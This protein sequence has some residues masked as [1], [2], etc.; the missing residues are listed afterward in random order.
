MRTII[1]LIAFLILPGWAFT[2]NW[3]QVYNPL[4]QSS[5]PSI[6]K[7]QNIQTQYGKEI[8]VRV[9]GLT[10]APYI[11]CSGCPN[12]FNNLKFNRYIKNSFIAYNDFLKCDR[13]TDGI[14]EQCLFSPV[15]NYAISKTDSNLIIR[16]YIVDYTG[17][18][19]QSASYK[20]VDLTTNGGANF[21]T[22]FSNF[23]SF[24]GLDISV[25]DDNIMV[26][27]KG[28]SLYKS[29]NRGMNWQYIRSFNTAT[30]IKINPVNPSMLYI[31]ATGGLYVSSNGGVNFTNVLPQTL[32]NLTF[33]DSQIIY[34]YTNNAVYKS[35]DSG[36]NW[37]ITFS[38]TG[39]IINCLETDPSNSNVVFAGCSNG[40]WRSTNSGAVFTKYN[41]TFPQSNNVLNVLK[42]PASGD[43]VY[44]VTPRGIFKVSAM[45]VNAANT[46]H[47]I[48]D[49]FEIYEIYPNP[50]N[51]SAVI[52]VNLNRN[53]NITLGLYNVTGREVLNVAGGYF[54]IGKYSFRISAETLSGGIYFAVLKS[55]DQISTK[56]IA[57]LK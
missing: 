15:D 54:D 34:G 11:C 1:F 22:K 29:T 14:M 42:T 28:D 18:I 23:P 6:E 26:I 8:M 33:Q 20:R 38:G 39:F 43:S 25:S 45:L 57:F 55:S 56:R 17:S 48:P 51:P 13:C 32:K 27:I 49:K 44:A 30:L 52:N 40:L 10:G 3:E 19:C 7:S 24:G 53:G 9:T 36:A 21:T 46:S 16:V 4:T 41:N 47:Q 35:T 37:N 12:N 2:Q 5:V 50:F 31:V